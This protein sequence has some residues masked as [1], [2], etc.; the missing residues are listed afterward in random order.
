MSGL[1]QFIHLDCYPRAAI[2]GIGEAMRVPAYC[3]HVLQPIEP[4]QVF[5]ANLNDVGDEALRQSLQARDR[6]GRR[7][8]SNGAVFGAGVV[9]YPLPAREMDVFDKDVYGYWV[10]CS[11]GWLRCEHGE[12]LKAVLEHTDEDHYHLHYYPE[13]SLGPDGRL[14]FS[15]AHPGRHALNDAVDRGVCKAAQNAAYVQAMI[16]YQSR[17]HAEVS[18]RFGH[19]RHGP[20]RQRID[21]ARH[22]VFREADE[23]LKRKRAELEM[24]YHARASQEEVNE[25]SLRVGAVEFIAVAVELQKKYQAEI[26]RLKEVLRAKGIDDEI[27]AETSLDSDLHDFSLWPKSR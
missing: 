14:D 18:R 23:H 22:K 1:M 20:R 21:R 25:R 16:D 11:L 6:A 27:S 10:Q 12:S 4:T 8:R 24:E 9:T 13:P 3:R 2:G 19:D 26:A 17:F 7:L 5:G 15:K